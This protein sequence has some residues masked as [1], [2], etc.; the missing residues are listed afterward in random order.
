MLASLK[1]KSNYPQIIFYLMITMIGASIV[2][3]FLSAAWSRVFFFNTFYLSLFYI[4]INKRRVPTHP[5]RLIVYI[6]IVIGL[7]KLSW[8]LIEYIGNP[9]INSDNAYLNS[10]KRLIFAGIIGWAL[11]LR[12]EY[13]NETIKKWFFIAVLISFSVA[14]ISGFYQIFFSTTPRIDFYLGYATDSAYMYCAIALC[15]LLMVSRHKT[16]LARLSAIC[17]FAVSFFIIFKTET[18]NVL[19]FFPVILMIC[20]NIW[21]ENSVRNFVITVVAIVLIFLSGYN[22]Y[23]VPS[24]NKTY[25]EVNIYNEYNGNTMGSVAARLAL[26]RV[27]Y[28]LF[29]QHPWGMSLEE[30]RKLADEYTSRTDSNKIAM[31]YINIHLHNEI[32]ETLSLQ[33]IQGVFVMLLAYIALLFSAF[34]QKNNIL[35]GLALIIITVGFTDVVFISR[36]QTIFFSLLLIMSMLVSPARTKETASLSRT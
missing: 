27:G 21:K 26:W 22:K 13:I 25:D 14:T 9:D 36:E 6:L 19:I 8:F 1:N 23:I 34:R 18:R 17:I 12:P 33:G 2:L 31:I 35:L 24:I 10:G 7:S 5:L 16:L 4:V 30:R 20:L 15:A 28:E 32:L 11:F 29:K 3:N